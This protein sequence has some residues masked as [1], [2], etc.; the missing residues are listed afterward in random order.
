M[1]ECHI[2]GCKREGVRKLKIDGIINDWY[3][4]LHLYTIASCINSKLCRRK[5]FDDEREEIENI[6]K[7]KKRKKYTKKRKIDWL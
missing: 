2:E 3:C 7:E 5:F 1:S 6:L 4:K